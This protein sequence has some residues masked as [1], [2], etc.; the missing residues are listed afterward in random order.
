MYLI[1]GPCPFTRPSPAFVVV[2]VVV[3]V[4]VDV[5]GFFVCSALIEYVVC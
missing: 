2:V 1:V 3:V 5:A 4:V